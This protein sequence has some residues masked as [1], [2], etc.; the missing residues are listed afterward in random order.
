MNKFTLFGVL[1]FVMATSDDQRFSHLGSA[2][3]GGAV[4]AYLLSSS[5]EVS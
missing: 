4:G 1:G 2:I 3:V 5:A